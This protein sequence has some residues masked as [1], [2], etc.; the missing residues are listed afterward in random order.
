MTLEARMPLMRDGT[1]KPIALSRASALLRR[2][3][4]LLSGLPV[5][6]I[7]ERRGRG[8]VVREGA[9]CPPR[10]QREEPFAGLPCSRVQLDTERH[11][12]D[13]YTDRRCAGARRTAP[14]VFARP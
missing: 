13:V 9:N 2:P 1:P 14:R 7:E 6:A 8:V 4:P 5:R 12:P 11:A 10:M 3:V